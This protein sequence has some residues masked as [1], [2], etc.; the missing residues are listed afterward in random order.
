MCIMS[1]R[2]RYNVKTVCVCV[3]VCALQRNRILLQKGH[4]CSNSPPSYLSLLNYLIYHEIY[5]LFQLRARRNRFTCVRQQRYN[6]CK[7]LI[8]HS[9]Y[10]VIRCHQYSHNEFIFIVKMSVAPSTLALS[11]C[12]CFW[13]AAGG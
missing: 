1:R 12:R 5:L 8:F 11:L 4:V 3:C 10:C 9:I 2:H 6:C 13:I 7:L